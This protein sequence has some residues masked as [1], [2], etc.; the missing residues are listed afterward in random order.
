M[1]NS[2]RIGLVTSTFM[3]EE[4]TKRELADFILSAKSLSMG[5]MVK[6]FEEDFAAKQ[7]R[8]YAVCVNSGGSANLLLLQSLMN[9]GEIRP[10]ARIGISALTWSTNVTPVIQLGLIPVAIDIAIESLNVGTE[11]LS[12]VLD[13]IDV[14]FG[15]NVLGFASD[16]DKIRECCEAADVLFI[17]DNCESL[18]SSVKDKLLGNF[19]KAATFSFFVAHHISTIEG[20]MIVTDDTDL[21][22]ALLMAR[23]NG[24]DRNIPAHR[25]DKLRSRHSVD[26]F[27]ASYTFYDLSFNIR[28]TEITGFLGCSQLKYWDSIVKAREKSFK[29]FHDAIKANERLRSYELGHMSTVSCFAIPVIARDKDAFGYYK[30]LFMDNGV[31]IRPIIAGN[32]AKQPFY[33]KY[34]S[35]IGEHPNCDIVHQHG[36]YFTNSP[37]LTGDQRRKLVALLD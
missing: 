4:D 12:E 33:R 15:T 20:G 2:G 17:E 28:P 21:Y 19:G 9:I 36:F 22:E 13:D 7:Q 34:V 32:I 16:I 18:G 24:W 11:Q 5:L 8:R 3:D 26:E 25:Q 30:S 31:E 29:Q 35:D 6:K 10:G 27:Y 14:Y 23:A 37:E 1:S